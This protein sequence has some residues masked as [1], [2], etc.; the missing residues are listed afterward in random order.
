MISCYPPYCD[1]TYKDDFRLANRLVV[2]L[3]IDGLAAPEQTV[4]DQENSQQDQN[5]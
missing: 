1:F 5:T 3:G 2:A 4:T